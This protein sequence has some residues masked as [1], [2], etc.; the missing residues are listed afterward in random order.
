[1]DTETSKIVYNPLGRETMAKERKTYTREF[2]IE[3]V[4]L[5]ERSGR[6][7]AEIANELGM[8]PSSLSR[9][10]QKYGT[11]AEAVPPGRGDLKPEEER[12][13]ELERENEILRQ[14]RDILKKAVAI[15][16]QPSR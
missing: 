12:I 8:A 3:A 4:R 10:K 2:K 13:R 9:W 14:E 15:F 1:V 6:T 5:L 11:D 16:S 7:Q